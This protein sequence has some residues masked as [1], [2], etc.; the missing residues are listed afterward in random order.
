MINIVGLGPGSKNALTVGT[1]DL[2]RSGDKVFLRTVKH[3]TVEYID[4]LGIKYKSFDDYYDT[5]EKFEQVYSQIANTI[6]EEDRDN[7]NVVYGVPG[8]PLMAE[9]S[10]TMLIKLC[11]E[12]GLKYKIYPAVSFVDA[13]ME[14]LKIDPV[15][16]IKILDAF[17]INSTIPDK[18][19]GLIVTQVYDKLIASEVKLSLM[20]YYNDET[21]VWFVRAAGIEG[22]ENIRKIKLYELDRQ[23]DIDHLTSIFVPKDIE[24]NKDF[25]D[26]L[27]IMSKLR[28]EDGCPWDREQSHESLKKYLIEEAYEVIEAIDE[29]DENKLVEELGD[30]LLQVVF[31]AQLGKEDGYFDINDVIEGICKKMIDRHPHVFGNVNANTSEQV[32]NNWDIIKK[33]E[34]GLKSYTDTMKHIPKCLPALMRAEKVQDKAKKAGFDWDHVEDAL[35]KVKEELQEVE[36]VYKGENRARILEELGD[37]LFSVV[38]VARFLDIDAE[39]ALVYT[40]DKFIYRFEYIECNCKKAGMKIENMSL[41]QMD[42]LWNEAKKFR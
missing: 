14:S 6:V 31:H 36:D 5:M 13:L 28:S 15:E 11:D 4:S 24:N 10:V 33:K 37:L 7:I 16:G 19:I 29:K 35:N 42:K 17:D 22:M 23:E 30:V 21:E 20:K 3:P 8:H 25:R 41:E 18:R 9:K 34:Q 39:S 32:L 38:N 12:K 26:L 40:I 1:I 2:L 27:D